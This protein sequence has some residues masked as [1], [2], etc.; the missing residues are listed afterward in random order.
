MEEHL[1]V[2]RLRDLSSNPTFKFSIPKLLIF[3]F[4]KNL[5]NLLLT[6]YSTLF[7]FNI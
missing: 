7:Y 6:E 5:N 2:S 4:L 1:P 3:F